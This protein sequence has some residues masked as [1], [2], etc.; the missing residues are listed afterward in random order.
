MEKGLIVV[1]LT[2]QYNQERESR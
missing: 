2:C 1:V